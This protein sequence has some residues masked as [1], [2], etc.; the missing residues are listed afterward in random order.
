MRASAV[1][2]HAYIKY[3]LGA[4]VV[5]CLLPIGHEYFCRD[6]ERDRLN[7]LTL[8]TAT[9]LHTYGIT[10]W[11]TSGTLLGVHLDKQARLADFDADFSILVADAFAVRNLPWARYGLVMF[12]GF[13]GF[14][15]K[16]R[17]RDT[18][19]VDLLVVYS[20][21]ACTSIR[22]GSPPLEQPPFE[23]A[24]VPSAFT[25]TL[26][27]AAFST[28]VLHIPNQT[29]AMMR[30]Q[31]GNYKPEPPTGLHQV[32]MATLEKYV[33]TKMVMPHISILSPRMP[34]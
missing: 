18:F 9:A 8:Q 30:W 17:T 16:A 13:G 3:G 23:Y 19:R 5:V 24:L 7:A 2:M 20:D 27:T 31:Y 14:R 32:L 10:Y 11:A 6:T 34:Y 21:A 4:L 25:F 22:F 12:E 15:I 33:W 1:H 28:G 29:H 26:R